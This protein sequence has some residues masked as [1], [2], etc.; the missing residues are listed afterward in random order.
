LRARLATGLSK[1]PH[2]VGRIRLPHLSALLAYWSGHPPIHD[3]LAMLA[4]CYTTW[5]PAQAAEAAAPAPGSLPDLAML[6]HE[7][8]DSG[9]IVHR[10]IRLIDMLRPG[11]R[12]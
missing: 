12:T 6:R 10:G 4:R 7:A 11:N 2:E 5:K 3:L 9:L 1:L 8:P